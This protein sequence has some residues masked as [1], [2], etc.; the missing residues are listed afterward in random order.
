[1]INNNYVSVRI[2]TLNTQQTMGQI[3]HDTRHKKVDYLRNNNKNIFYNS[4]FFT[5]SYSI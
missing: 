5:I 2:K 1:M 4:F 3:N